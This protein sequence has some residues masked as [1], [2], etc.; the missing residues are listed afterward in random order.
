MID[1]CKL[2]KPAAGLIARYLIPVALITSA[3]KSEPGLVMKVSLGNLAAAF[4]A[5]GFAPVSAACARVVVA[6]T[7]APA[8]AA[9]PFKKERRWSVDCVSDADG[10]FL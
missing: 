9:V 10:V 2:R 7:T 8:A 4:S 3:M 1:S 6:A 5:A